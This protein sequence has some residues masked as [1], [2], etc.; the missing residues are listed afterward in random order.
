VLYSQN[1]LK[2]NT[3]AG[4]SKETPRQKMI[5]LMYLVLTAMLALNVSKDIL[6]GFVTVNESLE[7]TNAALIDNQIKTLS[8]FRDYAKGD[9][10]ARI[11]LKLTE[12]VFKITQGGYEY[13]AELKSHIVA[14][15]E[16]L[17]AKLA[18]TLK[19]RYTEKQD[20]FDTPTYILIGDDEASPKGGAM[21]A[22]ELKSKI[23][24]IHDEILARI[25]KLQ[26]NKSAKLLDA[27]YNRLVRKVKSIYPLDPTE[28]VDNVKETWETQNFNQLPLAA[29][30]TNLTKIQ[31][32]IKSIETSFM[33]ELA[34][35]SR[36]SKIK[37]DNF[38]AT[39]ISENVY[40]QL[41]QQFK[42][43]I[44][45]SA[46]SSDF[47]ENNMQVLLGGEYD[48]IKKTAIKEGEPIKSAGGIG[49]YE[50]STTATGEQ[51]IKGAIKLKNAFG[52]FEY[53]PY[54]YKYMV[55]APS[56]SVSPEKMNVMYIGL[57]NPVAVSA[58]GVAPSDL[59]VSVS[60][61]GAKLKSNGNGKYSMTATSK[62][63][64]MITV[65][66]KQSDGTIR[67]QGAPIKFR[68]KQVPSPIAKI[69]GKD[70][71]N[72][73]LEFTQN[74]LVKIGGVGAVLPNFVFEDVNF[75]VSSYTFSIVNSRGTYEEIKVAGSNLP[76]NAK[77]LIAEA[78]KGGKFYIEDI[79]AI[80][81]DG[82]RNLGDI[83]VKIK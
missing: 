72:G 50:T 28:K 69:G 2:L 73:A 43:N 64:C 47:N 54:E 39:V 31:N 7:R 37:L 57:E 77:K 63:D 81:P 38:S 61:C 5:G 60:G 1:P 26:K 35:A 16:K 12:E 78:K 71:S 79:V 74:E 42:A 45:L 52:E 76:A 80:G 8:D 27:D 68:V 34:N 55:A 41:G 30:I 14:K 21:T 46:S 53:Y 48:F 10:I 13:V 83:K 44:F 51:I 17:D 23:I 6:K 4:N 40:V 9:S 36:K 24:F 20:D 25:E 15:T 19:L 58:A 65:S 66:A 62:G 32:D 82:K 49:T 33:G 59:V 70:A 18:D 75:K 29:V 56:V 3:M 11:H 67:Q 22:K